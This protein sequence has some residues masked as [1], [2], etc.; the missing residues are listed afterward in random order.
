MHVWIMVSAKRASLDVG[1]LIRDSL[2]LD[3][4]EVLGLYDVV[5]RADVESLSDLWENHI[6]LINSLPLVGGCTTYL[7]LSERTKKVYRRPSAFILIKAAQSEH[8][9]I[10]DKIFDIEEVQKVDI[11]LGAYDMI[12]EVITDLTGLFKVVRKVMNVSSNI[13]KTVTMVTFPKEKILLDAC[14]Q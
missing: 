8:K 1:K 5:V 11:V 7:S 10:Q 13:L 3:A 12:A 2:N 9:E 14:R 4:I 6:S